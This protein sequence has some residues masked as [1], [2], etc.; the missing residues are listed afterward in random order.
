[1]KQKLGLACCLVARPR[2]L[3][4]DE[5][6]VGVD[7]VSRRELWR[8]VEGLAKEGVSVVWSTAYLDEAERCDEVLLL[9]AGKLIG[10]GTPGHFMAAV[11]GRSFLVTVAPVEKRTLQRTLRSE[12]GVADASIQGSAVR[13]VLDPDAALPARLAD[14]AKPAG[15]RFEDAFIALLRQA[16]RSRPSGRPRLAVARAGGEGAAIETRNLVRRFGDFLAVDDVT[17]S[18]ARGEIFGLLGPNGAGKST[19]FRM[20]CGLLVPSSG[21]AQVAS[22]DLTR[23]RAAARAR[24]G[25][26]A[27]HFSLYGELS[28]RQN[29]EFFGGAYGLRGPR[30][31]ERID[32]VLERF[33]LQAVAA[34]RA[35]DLPL[36]Y[37]Q[38]LALGAA[39]IHKPEVLFLDEPTSGVD[40]LTRREFWERIGE[41]A[42]EGVSVLVTSHFMDEAEYCDRLAII[43][44]GRM[45]AMGTPDALKAANA[46]P[47]RPEP[48][49]E[50]AFVRLIEI[51]DGAGVRAGTAA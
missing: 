44:R 3:L 6:S 26:M 40:P 18:V 51:S 11:D 27:Q 28:V 43:Y 49:L 15:P 21:E 10:V 25:Y 2:L 33:E 24:I 7:P 30:L 45:I 12:P 23:G 32:W 4:L 38:R 46:T 36:G 22:M 39:L 31:A 8:I 29:L 20:L 42:D 17:F 48:S 16:G 9:D 41:L 37:K 1:M 35:G 14:I 13:L 47:D 50:D 5:P 34:G 19:V